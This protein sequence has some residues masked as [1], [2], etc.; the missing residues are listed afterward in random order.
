MKQSI[1]DASHQVIEAA[2]RIQKRIN[3][4]NGISAMNLRK[5]AEVLSAIPRGDHSRLSFR[6]H[7]PSGTDLRDEEKKKNI[8]IKK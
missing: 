8:I 5:N 4:P 7:L 2:D 1:D 3:W 6:I